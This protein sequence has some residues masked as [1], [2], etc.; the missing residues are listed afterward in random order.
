MSSE[1]FKFRKNDRIGAAGAEEDG[2]FLSSCFVDT[3]DLHLLQDLSDHRQIVLGRTGTGKSALLTKLRESKPE[4]VIEISPENLALTYVS[5]STILNFFSN[6]GVNLDPFFKLLWRHVLT[7]EV[8]SRCFE[9]TCKDRQKS[10]LDRLSSMFMGGS[11]HD[12]E[13]KEAVEYLKEWGKSFWL[14]TEFRVKEITQKLE[15]ELGAALSAQLGPSAA[16]IGSSSQSIERLSQEQKSE[17]H[18]RAQQ[19]VS[20]AQVQDL[21]K[22]INLLDT[23]L[24]DKQKKY[25]IVIDG[26]DE[27]WVEE[28]IRYRLIMALILTARDF[29]RVSNAKVIVA[30]RRDL[31]ERV[32]RLT[33]ESGFQ[34]EKFQSLYLP[35]VWKK[36]D[37]IELLDRRID[38]LVSRRYTKQ[39]VTHRDLLPKQYNSKPISEFIIEIA[40]RPR[41]V[42]SF[43]NS[44]ISAATNLAR[45]RVSEL[46]MAE[47]EYSRSRLRALGDEWSADYPCLLDFAA[48]LY[49]RPGSFKIA[50]IEDRDINE[51]CLRIS[52]EDPGGQGLLQKHAMKLVDCAISAHDFRIFLI[53]VF[54]QVGLI[55]LKITPHETAAWV[56]ELGKRVSAAEISDETSAVVHPAFH[57][58]LGIRSN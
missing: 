57:R 44:C 7:I 6:L 47:G 22:V 2:E 40:D 18:S 12:K 51:L 24:Q 35:L 31:I 48:I 41:D 30:I 17:L 29:I 50:T 3:G 32:F 34:E 8:L 53:Q 20:A 52:A 36:A 45:L 42:I 11:R 9:H 16:S 15:N 55:G 27:N 25:Y 19:I 54:Y 14:E 28:R 49:R 13:M 5:N 37:L 33:R 21:H 23:V 46:R 4:Y 39:K 10:L 58:A 1:V 26:L 43:F 56:N 38:A